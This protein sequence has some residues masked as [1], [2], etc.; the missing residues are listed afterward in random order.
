MAK[1]EKC[2]FSCTKYVVY[3]CLGKPRK[4]IKNA[5]VK[6]KNKLQKE[7]TNGLFPSYS[8]SIDDLQM[9]MNLEQRKALSNGELSS[10]VFAHKTRQAF[11]T[12]DQGARKL[13]EFYIGLESTQTIPHLFGW[14]SY[15][16][17]ILDNDKTVIIQEHEENGGRLSI[18]FEEVFLKALELIQIEKYPLDGGI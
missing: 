10:I 4:D 6:L 5:D 17:K 2:Y 14:L 8:I 16:G 7:I 12:D 11:L 15:I 3:E 1:A 9:V 13:S 18:Y